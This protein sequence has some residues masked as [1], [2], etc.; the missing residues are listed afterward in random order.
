MP[1]LLPIGLTNLIPA[2][3][4]SLSGPCREFGQRAGPA[5]PVSPQLLGRAPPREPLGPCS[6]ACPIVRSEEMQI[7][8]CFSWVGKAMGKKRW[9]VPALCAGFTVLSALPIVLGWPPAPSAW[10]AEAPGLQRLGCLF[11]ALVLGS[12]II[13][14]ARLDPE[15]GL[16]KAARHIGFVL[17]AALLTAV[18]FCT[19]DVLHLDW[20]WAQ[21]NGI[22]H[23]NY[24][25]PDQ[26][27][28]PITRDVVVDAPMQRRL[29]FFG[30]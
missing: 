11:L 28:V 19:V 4:L 21:Y 5:A 15:T 9:A 20:Q 17:L 2:D 3:G 25:P 10:F 26:Y 30:P 12:L 7:G 14:I 27:P 23:H 18:H 13:L 16:W 22:L 24:V 29:C 8:H 1:A 6:W